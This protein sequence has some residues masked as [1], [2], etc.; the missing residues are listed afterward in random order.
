MKQETFKSSQ[1]GLTKEDTTM[2]DRK[3]ESSSISNSNSSTTV[4][5]HRPLVSFPSSFPSSFINLSP[6]WSFTPGQGLLV[7]SFPLIAGAYLGYRRE[8]KQASI[9]NS[10]KTNEITHVLEQSTQRMTTAATTKTTLTKKAPMVV[11]EMITLTSPSNAGY[12]A[13]AFLYG[14]LLSIG[15]VSLLSSVVF[16]ASGCRSLDEMVQCCREWTPRSRKRIELYF[17]IKS[18]M[19]QWEKD[20]DVIATADMAEDEELEYFQNKYVGND[21]YEKTHLNDESK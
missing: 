17:G 14:S 12:F 3:G 16:Y 7:A 15:G 5:N 1:E 11:P 8:M 21:I 19:Q 2:N 4:V 10:T 20:E 13:R 18:S 9:M 6:S